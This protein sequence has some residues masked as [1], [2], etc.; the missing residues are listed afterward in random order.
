MYKFKVFERIICVFGLITLACAIYSSIYN[1]NYTNC[2]LPYANIFVPVCHSIGIILCLIILIKPLYPLM[3]A[4]LVLESLLTVIIGFEY[5]GI[6]F[7]SL[8]MLFLFC[9]KFYTKNSKIKYIISISVWMI[10]LPFLIPY[11]MPRFIMCF[12]CSILTFTLFS[13]IYQKIKVLLIPNIEKVNST[14]SNICKQPIGSIFS[15]KTLNITKRQTKILYYYLTTNMS[16]VD[17]G[18]IIYISDSLVKK[19]MKE[20]RKKLGVETSEE[21]KEA[22]KLYSITY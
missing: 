13:Y 3:T 22:L 5:L 6:L 14:L 8:A 7:Y 15:L 1:S 12:S 10:F 17:I 21:I 16:Y 19:E 11:G 9:N 4:T 18:N 2:F 20:I